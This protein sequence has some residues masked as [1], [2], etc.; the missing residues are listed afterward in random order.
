MA[1]LS[2][3]PGALLAAL[4]IAVPAV[5]DPEAGVDEHLARA[6]AALAA[7]RPADAASEL[8]GAMV[9]VAA[10]DTRSSVIVE[11]FVRAATELAG[12]D[13]DPSG[14]VPRLAAA[15]EQ[16]PAGA[17][18]RLERIALDRALVAA[19]LAAGTRSGLPRAPEDELLGRTSLPWEDASLL[20]EEIAALDPG[21]AAHA[22]TSAAA[23]AAATTP[24]APS[25]LAWAERAAA[26]GDPGASVLVAA[27][28][29]ALGREPEALARLEGAASPEAGAL[30]LSLRAPAIELERALEGRVTVHF[31]NVESLA[32][33]A[34]P[35][36]LDVALDDALL[37]LRTERDGSLDLASLA[38][39]GRLEGAVNGPEIALLTT[40]VVPSAHGET[41]SV[42]LPEGNALVVE[43]RGA[44][45]STRML[46][47]RPRVVLLATRHEDGVALALCL[48][49]T[50]APAPGRITLVQVADDVRGGKPVHFAASSGV[51]T[52]ESGLAF[53]PLDA[54]F[55]RVYAV[56]HADEGGVAWL[57]EPL[58]APPRSS[59]E[60]PLVA[61]FFERAL[62]RK[63]EIARARVLVRRARTE[64]GR[65]VLVHPGAGEKVQVLLV[66]AREKALAER[67]VT[68][69]ADGSAGFEAPLPPGFEGRVRLRARVEGE[70]ALTESGECIVAEPGSASLEAEL[71]GPTWAPPGAPVRFELHAHD[72]AGSPVAFARVDWRAS[73]EPAW[74][75]ERE[76]GGRLL[77]VTPPALFAPPALFDAVATD[78]SGTAAI[79]L[80][81][82][83]G[84]G[85]L[86]LRALVRDVTGRE[87]VARAVAAL[88]PSIPRLQVEWDRRFLA[89]G[90]DF[91]L[92]VTARGLDGR[93]LEVVK[94]TLEV[95]GPG[96]ARV[97]SSEI[98]T[99][100]EGRVRGT[101]KLAGSGVYEVAFVGS[102]SPAR[103][104]TEVFVLGRDGAL[105]SH[106]ERLALVPERDRYTPGETARFLVTAPEAWADA[107]AVVSARD[108]RGLVRAG[109]PRAVPLAK[110]VALIEVPL[111]A[112][113]APG[114]E[115]EVVCPREG[116]L[117]RASA[118]VHV[119]LVED[120]DVEVTADKPLYKP[121]EKPV[122][123]VR[124][125]GVDGLPRR[126]ASVA[127]SLEDADVV[128]A[129]LGLAPGEAPL[130]PRRHAAPLPPPG[131]IALGTD[132]NGIAQTTL[133][134]P[135]APG[136]TCVR[137]RVLARD[138]RFGA[139]SHVL[140]A[141]R[142]LALDAGFPAAVE[143]GD[144]LVATVSVR[145]D[146][147]KPATATLSLA[148]AATDVL[149]LE[150]EASRRFD[151]PPHG[152]ATLH[153]RVRPKKAGHAKLE[154]KLASPG[155][156]ETLSVT[157]TVSAPTLVPVSA[158]TATVGSDTAP[159]DS[160]DLV[161][162]IA[163]SVLLRV[164]SP[165][166]VL[167]DLVSELA[168]GDPAV[169]FVPALLA[170][171]ALE[172]VAFEAIAKRHGVDPAQ[173]L[174]PGETGKLPRDP[175]RNPIFSKV[176][177]GLLAE[178]G[179]AALAARLTPGGWSWRAGGEADLEATSAALEALAR[180]KEAGAPVAPELLAK[181]AA[182]LAVLLEKAGGSSGLARA[183]A[184]LALVRA[185]H[186][187]PLDKIAAG[188]GAD[189]REGRVVLALAA[190]LAAGTGPDAPRAR[191]AASGVLREGRATSAAGAARDLELHLLLAPD[192]S[193]A[194]TYADAAIAS[195]P[196]TALADPRGEAALA[197][198]LADYVRLAK[199]AALSGTVVVS[200]HG[201]R[202]AELKLAADD[203]LLTDAAIVV[204]P[205]A[206]LGTLALM[207]SK[208]SR[209]AVS[210]VALGPETPG[211]LE[212]RVETLART[213]AAEGDARWL[214][215]CWTPGSLHV[216]GIARLELTLR[217]TSPMDHVAIEQP[218]P[219]GFELLGSAPI[220]VDHLAP[221]E[222]RFTLLARPGV[223]GRFLLPPARLS[224]AG[225]PATA[226]NEVRLLVE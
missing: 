54:R 95:T 82:F 155:E 106:R 94:G 90:D 131:F 199:P 128:E 111:D 59:P 221:G 194:S 33:V 207:R 93:P 136:R 64:R 91:A 152:L 27:A 198:A 21:L 92:D 213:L 174:A 66:D 144:E 167:G 166:A 147:E 134:L 4:L 39:A 84:E 25:V 179:Q 79:A 191:E 115:L 216:G 73:F 168:A 9:G 24:R 149:A 71:V 57:A 17:A 218:L 188:L 51:P 45:A 77:A 103:G 34:R 189:A 193:P 175:R 197:R 30:A 8:R 47:L 118:R 20:L 7:H 2:V 159:V 145:N 107:H 42:S 49:S 184:A 146:G 18:N 38:A 203:P 137:A 80:P 85:R 222:H 120:L 143:L 187:A 96:G 117:E 124:V 164:E 205:K 76:P 225:V 176:R 139:D 182:A 23:L 105:A 89:A 1:R 201:K 55:S 154:A 181:G 16:V 104:G 215:A 151:V 177:V 69:D 43:A 217:T 186:A 190:V 10:V 200:A 141:R 98:A 195:R 163:S 129:A 101:V 192:G 178:E 74:E 208:G 211:P 110:G 132:D 37:A 165:A 12:A 183:E 67:E 133:T 19:L 121:G 224:V 83:S 40:R 162:P 185:G 58:E 99:N 202:V 32:V 122:V 148:S 114:L 88:A 44:G 78:A 142:R 6:E 220:A 68:L 81:A 15:R 123:R 170:R 53:A 11:R 41:L 13:L 97:S 22:F 26:L 52:D 116:A 56:A 61:A 28:L 172:S 50:G 169:A 62:L 48:A 31:R 72:P 63:G 153:V 75:A 109:F 173:L 87:G 60:R 29:A 140:V 204:E 14:G 206:P 161:A 158:A 157:L 70:P 86:V 100:K 126:G 127:L 156:D 196:V 226:G 35:I 219:A 112:G 210:V 138:G 36:A 5:A 113:W 130:L 212:R 125:H 65:R 214:R 209:V 119:G 135:D 160:V 223:A 171:R 3:L 150:G 102:G 180:A 46:L 108:D